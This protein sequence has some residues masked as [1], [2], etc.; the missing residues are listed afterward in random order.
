MWLKL[1]LMF[2]DDFVNRQVLDHTLG[3]SIEPLGTHQVSEPATF[4]LILLGLL[5]IVIGRFRRKK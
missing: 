2:V 1:Q 5:L 4:W 3:G